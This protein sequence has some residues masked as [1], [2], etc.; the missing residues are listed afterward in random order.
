MN[1]LHTVCYLAFFGI[2]LLGIFGWMQGFPDA[3]LIEFY[4]GIEPSLYVKTTAL[5][6][7]LRVLNSYK[8]DQF[9]FSV[10]HACSFFLSKGAHSFLVLYLQLI[11]FRKCLVVFFMLKIQYE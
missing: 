9:K 5:S 7:K 6:T 10:M 8:F 11:L 2:Q 1:T 3:K 4:S